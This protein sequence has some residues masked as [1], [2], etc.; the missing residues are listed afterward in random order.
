MITTRSNDYPQRAL[1][2]GDTLWTVSMQ[3]L[4]ANDLTTLERTAWLPNT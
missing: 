1:V 4:Q 3:G 2:I